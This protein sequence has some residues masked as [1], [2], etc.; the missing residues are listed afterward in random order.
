[1]NDFSVNITAFN[2]IQFANISAT[3]G[4][5]GT[6]TF[7]EF[8]MGTSLADVIPEPASL[9]LLITTLCVLPPTRRRAAI[10]PDR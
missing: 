7:D 8:R 6:A 1:V 3:G 5:G 2:H 10:R 4:A 9:A